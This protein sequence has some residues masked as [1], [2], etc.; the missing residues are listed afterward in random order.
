MPTD[1]P[2]WGWFDGQDISARVDGQTRR[3]LERDAARLLATPEGERL[4]RHLDSLTRRRVL[5]P[6]AGDATLRHLEGQRQ[7]VAYLEA[8]AQRG[9]ADPAILAET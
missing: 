7:L 9:R 2:G 4:F 8:L 6:D 3:A 5:G 1:I